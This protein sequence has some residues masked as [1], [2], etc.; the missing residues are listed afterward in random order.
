MRAKDFF[1][2]QTQLSTPKWGEGEACAFLSENLH[3]HNGD[4]LFVA[5]DDKHLEHLR[6]NFNFFAPDL[7]PIVFPSWD[8]LPYDRVSPSRDLMGK[9]SFALSQLTA[10]RGSQ[11]LILTTV[12]ALYQKL[13]L[14]SRFAGMSRVLKKAEKVNLDEFTS[15]LTK[16]GYTRTETVREMG[17]FALRGGIMDLYLAGYNDPLRCDFFGNQ[18]EEIKHFDALT[19]TSTTKLSGFTIYPLS[20]LV[21]TNSSI[22]Q[23]KQGYRELFGN[24]AAERDPL[25]KK[26]SEGQ[27]HGGM[28]HWLPL[29]ETGVTS[30]LSYL[31]DPLVVM[32]PE[33]GPALKA[34]HGQIQ[35]FYLARRQFQESDL[36]QIY[37]PLAPEQ[38]YFSE[39]EWDELVAG[40]KTRWIH[41]KEVASRDID[42]D[43]RLRGDDNEG[44]IDFVAARIDPN[45]N[46]Y[47]V[48]HDWVKGFKGRVVLAAQNSY[49]IERLSKIL[50][51]HELRHHVLVGKWPE[52]LSSS[53]KLLLAEFPTSHSFIYRDVAFV[54][55]EDLLGERITRKVKKRKSDTFLTEVS[56]LQVGDFVVHNDHGIGQFEGLE[57][58]TT[59]GVPH[60]CLKV[61]YQGGDRLFI[62]VENIEV[63]SKYGSEGGGGLLDKLGGVG[64]QTR[65]AK[66]KERI[67]EIAHYLIKLAAERASQQGE[68]MQAPAG[69]YDEFCARFPYPETDDQLKAIDEITTDL[70]SGKPMD[71]LVCGDV[72]FGKTEV[73]MRA[74]FQVTASGAQVVVVV[75]TTLLAMQHYKN[76][77]ARFEGFPVRIQQLSR[78]VPSRQAKLIKE[79]FK[80]GKVDI[81]IGT[82]AVLSKEVR[83][84]HMGLVIVDEE[85]HFGVSQKEKL[86]E[87]KAKTHI[88][89]LTA[90]PI[91]R[92]L[93]MALTGVRDLSLIATPPVDRMAIRTFIMPYDRVVI[94]E[95]LLREKYRGGQSFY[96]CPRLADIPKIA[97]QL[98]KLVPEI[99][100][101]IAHGKLTGPQLEKLMVDFAGGEFDVLVST[102]IV[103]SGIDVQ[104]ANTMVIH[105]SDMF[106]L[107]Q[108]YQLRGRVGR[109]KIR[110]YAY[111]TV[112]EGKTLT[113]SAEK[114]LHVMSTLDHLG[115]GFTLASHDLD[116]RGAGNLLGDEQSGHIK[117]VGIELYQNMLQEALAALKQDKEAEP[118]WSPQINL[119]VPILIPESYVTDLSTR[120]GLYR[121][122]SGLK[123]KAEIDEFGKELLDRFGKV[124]VEVHNLFDILECKIICRKIG[125]DKVDV[126]PKGAILGFYQNK[127]E[128]PEKLIHFVTLQKG[129]VKLRPDHKLVVVAAWES[130]EAKM[131]GVKKVLSALLQLSPEA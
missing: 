123:D 44:R 20:E 119:G 79:E 97:E 95:A 55:E 106:G 50:G 26:V 15:Y 117:E 16:L 112:P 57:T 21:L 53:E 103:E 2:H 129:R 30:L 41:E 77:K 99:K 87:L 116:I 107:A 56:A 13:P 40:C 71:R 59:M 12:N 62:P 93:Q 76:F 121:R 28:E 36:D 11:Q 104:S 105:R 45:Q 3:Q 24:K 61:I 4:I 131:R 130:V 51:E 82:H 46:I 67:G 32:A 101:A 80:K 29:F 65:K 6:Q 114:R 98:E 124:P 17:E 75:P 54:V 23:F 94:R 33:V 86:K 34:R 89:T 14:R 85:Q 48:F 5:R 118:E 126:G 47:E 100:F 74:A 128:S 96:V 10:S 60:D 68:V 1:S 37:Y 122:A 72:G 73:A 90:T 84:P 110:A 22:S 115:A 38:L 111:L 8:C 27:A 88:L 25:Y 9:R 83:P 35:E 52:V 7:T 43:S 78:F 69:T 39:E 102:N 66:A 18:L 49:S 64:W 113:E 42:L 70:A 120:L 19:Q 125:V 63:L 92:T 91:P 81:L 127:F 58:V 31:R 108:L 109:G